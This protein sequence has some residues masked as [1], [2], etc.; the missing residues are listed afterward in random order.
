MKLLDAGMD[1]GKIDS[2]YSMERRI[3]VENR[4]LEKATFIVT[5]TNQEI[6]EQY[7]LYE[8]YEKGS[9]RVTPPGV[10]LEKFFPYYYIDQPSLV[11]EEE[12]EKCLQA[13]IRIRQELDRFLVNPEKPLIL[14]IC[15][16]ETRKNI[17]GLIT[18]YGNDPELQSIANLAI[19]AGI[20]KD[21]TEKEKAERSILTDMLLLMDKF[22]LYG[23]LAIPKK[24]EID[25]EVPEYYRYT[26]SLRGVFVNPA[27]IEP[28]GLTLLE[29]ASSG[30][31]IV[32]TDNGGP[33]D[34]VKNCGNGLLVDVK[35]SEN[36]AS[37]V[38]K[39]LVEPEEW[40]EFSNNGII[41][42]KKHYSW[43]AHCTTFIE[44]LEEQGLLNLEKK[45]SKQ[46]I[47]KTMA[48]FR[49][50]LI[51]DIDN[52]LLGNRNYL[53]QLGQILKNNRQHLGFGVATGRNIE[54]A[55][56]VLQDNRVPLPR[57]LITSVGTE[58]YYCLKDQLVYD[59]GYE[60]HI[61]DK[62]EPFLIRSLLEPLP[63]LE[64]QLDLRKYK[65][66]FYIDEYSEEKIREIHEVLRKQKCR[67]NLIVAE[68]KMIDILPYRASKSNA[69]KYFAY[70]W[71]VYEDDIM[72]CGDSGNDYEMLRD[73]RNSVVVANH[74]KEL[75]GHKDLFYSNYP[76]AGAIIEGIEKYN[77]L[78]GVL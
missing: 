52:T 36:I 73:F 74:Q 64:I 48:G 22:N 10:D 72:V 59:K 24:H 43:K 35:K 76:N 33:K 37:T 69:I 71:D 8:N 16:P 57:V 55:L 28:F 17:E 44:Y 45:S 13:R 39:I 46:S 77:F 11:D 61:N 31:P 63:F 32:A 6:E 47:N 78:E 42:T 14:A 67:Y 9:F 70:K 40:Q 2:E 26:A 38:K 29:A 5:S 58:I 20:R 75:E 62:W 4:I 60:A 68:Q 3:E 50:F 41:N 51:T 7:S 18:A 15:R 30:L 1:E 49:K 27:F 12:R 65:I 66:S 56:E 25:Y 19:V 21:I 23:K 34:I 53:D 54:S